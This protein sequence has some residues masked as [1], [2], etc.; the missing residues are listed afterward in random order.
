MSLWESVVKDAE[1]LLEMRKDRVDIIKATSLSVF[2]EQFNHYYRPEVCE[3][4]MQEEKKRK[5][6][7]YD[8]LNAMIAQVKE[9]NPS[10]FSGDMKT[11][12]ISDLEEA[13]PPPYEDEEPPYADADELQADELKRAEA[14]VDSAR[15]RLS[16]KREEADT[17]LRQFNAFADSLLAY[18]FDRVNK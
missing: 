7:I 13:K 15:D 10:T 4:V 11:Q 16:E 2:E 6:D 3:N 18:E 5:G 8:N 9:W 12:M 17:K 1:G 14:L